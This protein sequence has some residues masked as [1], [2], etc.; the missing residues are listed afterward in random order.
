MRLQFAVDRSAF[1]SHTVQRP[2][3]VNFGGERSTESVRARCKAVYCWNFNSIK[4]YFAPGKSRLRCQLALNMRAEFEKVV[5]SQLLESVEMPLFTNVV[6]CMLN[7]DVTKFCA[8]NVPESPNVLSI[9]IQ[10]RSSICTYREKNRFQT[11]GQ[12]LSWK[13]HSNN[14]WIGN[15]NPPWF[16]NILCKFDTVFISL[17]LLVSYY[18]IWRMFVFLL[19]NL[20]MSL[21]VYT[22]KCILLS[23]YGSNCK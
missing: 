17:L 22:F 8:Q 9:I 15:N 11:D 20:K 14:S 1:T 2:K 3:E 23:L 16:W 19:S 4:R 7:V 13:G 12:N 18:S 5:I 21:L 6:A 10:F